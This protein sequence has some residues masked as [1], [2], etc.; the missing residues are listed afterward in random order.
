MTKRIRLSK[1]FSAIQ[2]HLC[3]DDNIPKKFPMAGS[4]KYWNTLNSYYRSKFTKNKERCVVFKSDNG[5]V[6]KCWPK[7]KQRRPRSD[8]S[9]RSS[10]NWIYAVCLSMSVP[11]FSAISVICI[12]MFMLLILYSTRSY[13]EGEKR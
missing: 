10:L 8:C 7:S 3:G 5:D 13:S 4:Q 6:S 12:Q 1:Q 11:V 2:F 9:K